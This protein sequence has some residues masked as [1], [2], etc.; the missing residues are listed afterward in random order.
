MEPSKSS[1][2]YIYV[3]SASLYFPHRGKNS[4]A[5]L[6]LQ[7]LTKENFHS[8]KRAMS[9][10]LSAKKKI[11][12]ITKV[13]EKPNDDNYPV[14]IWIRCNDLLLSWLKNSLSKKIAY[15]VLLMTA[16]AVV[17]NDL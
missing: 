10:V 13:I 5:V 8:W 7:E 1:L 12:F 3:H 11:G 6:I 15:S 16:T 14:N 4:R 17:W 2:S 9:I